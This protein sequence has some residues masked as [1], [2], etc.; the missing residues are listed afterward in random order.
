MSGSIDQAEEGSAAHSVNSLMN[1]RGL[2]HA[3]PKETSS[4]MVRDRWV[5]RDMEVPRCGRPMAFG[6]WGGPDGCGLWAVRTAVE[7]TPTE[8]MQTRAIAACAAQKDSGPRN[9]LIG[10]IS[11]WVNALVELLMA[12]LNPATRPLSLRCVCPLIPLPRLPFHNHGQHP[13]HS[14]PT[15]LGLPLFLS[16]PLIV[17]IVL[18]PI[19]KT[20]STDRPHRPRP[21]FAAPPSPGLRF[22][23]CALPFDTCTLLPHLG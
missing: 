7:P 19:S 13:P 16:T 2:G 10:L 9:G 4:I 15:S 5:S 1:G 20:P 11:E 8:C 17:L 14:T 21:S 3:E 12:I 22:A 18:W 23:F 6:A